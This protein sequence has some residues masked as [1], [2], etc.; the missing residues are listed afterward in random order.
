MAS[1][2]LS[3]RWCSLASRWNA[4]TAVERAVVL[5]PG[6]FEQ[7]G[8]AAAFELGDDLFE[9]A[10]PVASSTWRSA[11]RRI[12]TFTSPTSVSCGEELLRGAEE[13]RAVDAVDDDVLVEQPVF[14]IGV[15]LVVVRRSA[16]RAALR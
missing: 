16:G 14:V 11:R 13:Q 5:G 3:K 8:D 1:S 7:D 9:R 6:A 12:T 10:A 2:R 4:P 15:D